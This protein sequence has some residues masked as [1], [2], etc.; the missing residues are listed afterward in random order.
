MAGNFSIFDCHPFY[1]LE[2]HSLFS[3]FSIPLDK[4]DWKISS[5]DLQIESSQIFTILIL[6]KSWPWVLFVSR[7][8]IIFRIS[9]FEKSIVVSD[10]HVFSE[11]VAGSSLLFLST[12][13]WSAEK[14][15][16]ISAFSLK[17]IYL[18]VLKVEFEG[19]FYCWKR[20]LKENFTL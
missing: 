3:I 5:K 9:L 16:N 6:I 10:S 13:H 11:R 12:E 17:S 7:F 14:L 1:E 2:P 15:L 19:F 4:Q 20:S 18:D 8:L